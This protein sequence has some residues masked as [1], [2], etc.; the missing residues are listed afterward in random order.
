SHRLTDT[1]G[2]PGILVRH[3]AGMGV[4]MVEVAWPDAGLVQRSADHPG[5]TGAYL[6]DVHPGREA[7]NLAEDASPATVSMPTLLQADCTG[8]LRQH[9]AIAVAVEGSRRLLRVGLR[10][11]LSEERE[12]DQRDRND[13]GVCPAGQDHVRGA[14][15]DDPGRLPQ[16][17][18]PG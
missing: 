14:S 8:S 12:P 11:H 16:G 5:Q 9:L 10:G 3:P 2:F 15:A 17:Q 4:D 6:A 18:Q 7:D 13:P 1:P